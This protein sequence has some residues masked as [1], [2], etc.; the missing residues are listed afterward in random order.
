[1]RPDQNNQQ[2]LAVSD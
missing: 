2:K 1:L